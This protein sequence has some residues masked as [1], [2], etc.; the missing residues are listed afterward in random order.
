MTVSMAGGDPAALEELAEALG[1]E[2]ASTLVISP[3]RRPCLGVTCKA[4]R[5]AGD[6]YADAD[7]WLWW[8]WAERITAVGDSQVAARC[9]AAMLRGHVPA[10]GQ[11]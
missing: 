4:S 5:A 9:V 2:F 7:G 6:I 10:R 8:S 3:G 11:R 1:P